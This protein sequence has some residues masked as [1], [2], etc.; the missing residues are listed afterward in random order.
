MI[1]PEDK[2][3]EKDISIYISEAP[4][5]SFRFGNL[6][7]IPW[8]SYEELKP[9][10]GVT[11]PLYDPNEF[12][13]PQLFGDEE[14]GDAKQLSEGNYGEVLFSPS[15]N[16][17]F[18]RAKKRDTDEKTKKLQDELL[19]EI[20]IT[21]IISTVYEDCFVKVLGYYKDPLTGGVWM[22]M[23]K[24][25]GS[26]RKYVTDHHTS[27]DLTL[28]TCLNIL[29][30]S[31]H[32]L[33]RISHRFLHRDIAARNFL[34]SEIGAVLK[35]VLGDFGLLHA[36]P[37]K[38]GNVETAWGCNFRIA[39]PETL[40]PEEKKSVR[41]YNEKTEVF[42]FGVYI[43]EVFSAGEVPWKDC[44]FEYVRDEVLK[45][46]KLPKLPPSLC[47]E[48]V[49]NLIEDCW[50]FDPKDRPSMEDV[51]DALKRLR[52]TLPDFV[53][54]GKALSVDVVDDGYPEDE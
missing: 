16:V 17:V 52:T 41:I 6:Q 2:V 25:D 29:E 39:A 30:Q 45:G 24:M 11:S 4:E 36:L 27:G 34:I 43:W 26:V 5:E 18:K 8:T 35:V 44:T 10:F 31:A 12:P 20:E 37:P 32:C 54:R 21:R 40:S 22:V 33:Y 15:K 47:P 19:K 50:K 49:W 9:F 53:L 13:V 38:Y 23:E 1:E 48:E 51:W 28:H 14:L 3:A 42:A 7:G 46:G